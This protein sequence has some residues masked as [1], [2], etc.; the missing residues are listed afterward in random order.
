MGA[1]RGFFGVAAGLVCDTM[2]CPADGEAAPLLPVPFCLGSSSMVC[3]SC[4]KRDVE[5]YG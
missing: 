5:L 3:V 1:L 4:P 2:V